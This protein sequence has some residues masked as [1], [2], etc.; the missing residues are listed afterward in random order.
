VGPLAGD[1]LARA[2]RVAAFLSSAGLEAN[3]V[4]DVKKEIWKKLVL[5]AA[6]LP[7]AA[8]TGLSAGRLA[9]HPGMLEL[10]DG[11]TREAVAVARALGHA[12]DAGERINSIT[13]A[14]VTVADDVGVE[15]PLN[16]ALYA[17]VSGLERSRGLA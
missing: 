5:N 14:V 10:I 1:D 17:L 11:V 7:T 13:G 8:L 2:Q 3:A 9:A 15:V 6:T 12:I 4:T 16:R